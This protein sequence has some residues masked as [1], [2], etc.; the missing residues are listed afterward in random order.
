MGATSISTRIYRACDG[1]TAPRGEGYYLAI[2]FEFGFKKLFI[3]S[4][5][6]PG[7]EEGS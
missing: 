7:G 6:S 1:V 5:S 2:A 4:L 3:F